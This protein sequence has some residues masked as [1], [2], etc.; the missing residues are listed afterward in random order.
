[1]SGKTGFKTPHGHLEYL[2][3]YFVLANAPLDKILIYSLDHEQHSSHVQAVLER[4]LEN[5]QFI[6]AEKCVLLY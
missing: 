1:M 6:K 2:V 3:T 5:Q 4:F